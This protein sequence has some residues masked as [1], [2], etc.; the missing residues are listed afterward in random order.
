MLISVDSSSNKLH[1]TDFSLKLQL[2]V[3]TL[4]SAASRSLLRELCSFSSRC[5][6]SRLDGMRANIDACRVAAAVRQS[7]QH[8]CCVSGRLG[9]VGVIPVRDYQCCY[10][11]T[12][13]EQTSVRRVLISCAL[14]LLYS[15]CYS[16]SRQ[17]HFQS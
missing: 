14:I 6:G 5:N 2:R 8:A 1:S 10:V 17:I 11:G 9:A 7:G 4:F 15:C 13:A 16:R 12:A 3:C